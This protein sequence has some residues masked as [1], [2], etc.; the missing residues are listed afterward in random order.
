M[1]ILTIQIPKERNDLPPIN[2]DRKLAKIDK[3]LLKWKGKYL[4]ICGKITLTNSLVISQFTYLLMVLPTPSD[5]LLNYMNQKIFCFIW[6]G[7]PDKI[8]RAHL[9]NEYEFGG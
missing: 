9:Y 2:V 6:N 5:L 8:K 3:I 1:D 7:K 4:S